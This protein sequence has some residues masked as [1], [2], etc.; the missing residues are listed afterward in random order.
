MNGTQPQK[1][2]T[3]FICLW[4]AVSLPHR[5]ANEWWQVLSNG[6]KDETHVS[7]TCHKQEPHNIC[8][9]Q[10]QFTF[11][12]KKGTFWGSSLVIQ[13]LFFSLLNRSTYLI[14]YALP[15]SFMYHCLLYVSM[16]AHKE[17]VVRMFSPQSPIPWALLYLTHGN[18]DVLNQ[19]LLVLQVLKSHWH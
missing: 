9:H 19:I 8:L 4:T 12:R 17:N 14:I 7:L 6:P 15:I 5:T 1:I 16:L 18:R 11:K 2:L 3:E 10:L 13:L